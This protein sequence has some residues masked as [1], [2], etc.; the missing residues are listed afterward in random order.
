MII[1]FGGID[2]I[3]RRKTNSNRPTLFQVC[4]ALKIAGVGAAAPAALQFCIMISESN[5]VL[6][7]YMLRIEDTGRRSPL[8]TRYCSIKL[9]R[10]SG[11]ALFSP[12]SSALLIRTM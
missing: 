11:P 2:L 1:I 4:V 8:E 5:V 10:Y 7:G 3:K 12:V 9:G 6:G